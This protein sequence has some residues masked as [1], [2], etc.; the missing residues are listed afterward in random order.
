APDAA[1]RRAAVETAE[2]HDAAELYDDVTALLGD[3]DDA[4]RAAA[5]G[6]VLRSHPD[7]ARVLASALSS[8][9]PEA[10]ALAVAA[11]GRKIPD[12]ARKEIRAALADPPDRA[13][14]PP[15]A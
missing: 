4:V 2:R 14:A 7:A 12:L 15:P 10:R 11:L 1:A 13:R 3:E 8:G 5:A 6:A 9:S